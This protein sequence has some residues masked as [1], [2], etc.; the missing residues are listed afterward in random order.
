MKQGPILSGYD[1]MWLFVM[2][3][4]PTTTKRE[5]R[6]AAAFRN[7]LLDEGFDMVQFSVYHRLLASTRRADRVMDQIAG[8]I[9]ESGR[10]MSLLVT[11]RQYENARIYHG[12]A[13]PGGGKNPSQL[14]L[15]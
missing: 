4:L 14:A 9:P 13:P 3:D 7:M 11:D 15:F 1:L 12:K 6:A 2:F 8:D 5:R 10:V